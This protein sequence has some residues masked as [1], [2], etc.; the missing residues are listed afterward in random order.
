MGCVKSWQGVS[1]VCWICS[2]LRCIGVLSSSSKDSSS[3]WVQ[4]WLNCRIVRSNHPRS[5][6]TPLSDE[7]VITRVIR[8]TS[9]CSDYVYVGRC[10]RSID[11]R[12]LAIA[13]KRRLSPS[14]TRTGDNDARVVF[15]IVMPATSLSDIFALVCRH[16]IARWIFEWSWMSVG[17]SRDLIV[18]H[19]NLFPFR[20]NKNPLI[21]LLGV[22]E[23]VRTRFPLYSRLGNYCSPFS[24]LYNSVYNI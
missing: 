23:Y 6:R 8:V 2:G 15:T 3:R 7:C 17:V 18:I 11:S 10:T 24:R 22:L 21:F 16:E 5:S 13:I 4:N 20:E 19:C 12:W 1:R 9:L 14:M